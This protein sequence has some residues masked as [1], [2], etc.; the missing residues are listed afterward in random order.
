[1]NDPNQRLA[2][3][4]MVAAVIGFGFLQGA[5]LLDPASGPYSHHAFALLGLVVDG[6]TFLVVAVLSYHAKIER[7]EGLFVIGAFAAAVHIVLDVVAPSNT[8]SFIVM[9]IASGIG[10]SLNVLC[11]M[12]VFVSYRSRMALL[13]IALGYAVDVAIQPMKSML[14]QFEIVVFALVY[15][16]SIVLLF[17]C[18]K[19]NGAVAQMYQEVQEPTTTLAEAYSRTRRAIAAT[20]AFSF[21]CGF[22]LE[23]DYLATGLEYAQTTLTSSICF[24]CAVM[25]VVLLLVLKIRKANIDYVCP[26]AAICVSASVVFRGF[27]IGGD[28]VAGCV[29]TATL[30]SF[31]VL[32]WLMFISEARERMLP[33]FFLL[34]LALGVARLSVAAGRFAG[35][36]V[37]AMFDIDAAT[38]S[39]MALWALATAV[40]LVFFFSLRS[41]SK[42]SDDASG[43]RRVSSS[44]EDTKEREDTAGDAPAKNGLDGDFAGAGSF[45]EQCRPESD[46]RRIVSGKRKADEEG[47]QH[48][49]EGMMR[50]FDAAFDSLVETYG[51]SAREGEV[52]KEFAMGRSAHYI[53]EWYM[54]SEH[55]VKTHIRRA[56]AKLDVHSRQEL[57]DRIEEMESRILSGK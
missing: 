53:A 16:C 31:Y 4:L 49:V 42:Y 18:L 30:V 33:A 43:V 46:G 38:V 39:M 10:W 44:M 52:L 13:M 1:M 26:L 15:A 7:P 3:P 54:L 27:G 25:M 14:P 50:D 8:V 41:R 6:F 45:E 22:V 17:A 40:S 55:T 20:F 23:S 19:N 9:Q 28:Y 51:L 36:G 12:A 2:R 34:G 37:H 35:E 11:W 24:W 21:V 57:L 56:Y 48:A 5:R 47:A 32:L 29:M